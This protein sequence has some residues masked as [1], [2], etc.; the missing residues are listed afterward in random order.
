LPSPTLAKI[1]LPY[2][3][4]STQ[5]FEALS[6]LPY[7]ALLDSNSY[8]GKFGRFDIICADPDW[9]LQHQQQ[10]TQLIDRQGNRQPVAQ[11]PFE[12]L[13][14]L[15]VE[16][17]FN[18]EPTGELPFCG[19]ALGFWSYD[20]GRCYL[21]QTAV[22]QR[23]DKPLDLADM[24]IGIYGWAICV[25]HELKRTTLASQTLEPSQLELVAQHLDQQ[26]NNYDFQLCEP[27]VSNMSPQTY[28]QCFN[29]VIDYIHAGDC[30]QV[31]LAQRFSS[32]YR[33]NSWQAY[34]HLRRKTRTPFSAFLETP[35]G[36][37]LSL[38]PERFI[39]VID[40]QVETRPIKGTRPRHQD[41]IK[42]QA[43]K[44]QLADSD[45]DRAENLMI[46]D[47]LRND[48]GR[49]CLTGTVEVPELFKIESYPNVHHMVTV[50][51]AKLADPIDAVDLLKHSFPGGS[52]TGAPKIR[53]MQIIDELE[54]HQRSAYC[55]SIGYIGFNG[56]MDSN[57]CIRTL[58]ATKPNT[59]QGTGQIHCWAGG[60][61][62]AD[63][64]CEAE[65][66]ETFDKVNNLLNGL[67][68]AF[69]AD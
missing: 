9:V 50:I 10:Q 5:L 38:S 21:P 57:I 55:G 48:L 65:Y 24:Q 52:I 15:L 8:G 69:L 42:D 60:G 58:V 59:E 13:K 22:K 3:P 63:S 40:S 45:K 46:V 18:G 36:S 62:V 68:Q 49:S 2:D 19:G 44:Q 31:N 26:G 47:L 14:T 23:A 27:F 56:R 35:T 30:Y 1:E 20:L 25:D 6:H 54:P 32:H 51:T 29:K 34:K 17:G 39:Q 37:L 12:A 11:Q 53:A 61:I 41:P 4:D 33:G 64:D 66:Q 67:E 16:Q 28:R 43:L 7:P